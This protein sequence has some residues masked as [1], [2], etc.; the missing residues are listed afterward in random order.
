MKTTEIG[1]ELDE[2]MD[3]S[4]QAI[5]LRNRLADTRRNHAQLLAERDESWAKEWTYCPKFG[6]YS[7]KPR[8]SPL[9]SLNWSNACAGSPRSLSNN[10]TTKIADEPEQHTCATETICARRYSRSGTFSPAS[11]NRCDAKQPRVKLR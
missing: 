9:K 11:S 8:H 7:L 3:L 2:A 1:T 5:A 6:D 10:A 4:H